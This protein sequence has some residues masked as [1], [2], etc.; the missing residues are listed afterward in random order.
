VPRETSSP[1]EGA[2]KEPILTEDELAQVN[3]L[4]LWAQ[5][6]DDCMLF[7]QLVTMPRLMEFVYL[8]AI[9]TGGSRKRSANET[10]RVLVDL[11]PPATIT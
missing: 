10:T 7:S 6:H 1:S 4:L 3:K 5:M 9:T 2:N 8:V 11:S